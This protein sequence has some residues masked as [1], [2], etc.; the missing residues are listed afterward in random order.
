LRA[1]SPSD[2]LAGATPYL[3]MMGTL[4]GAHL[5]AKGALAARARLKNSAAD[6]AFLETRIAVAEFFA[7]QLL[8]PTTALLAPIMRGASGAF[9]LEADALAQ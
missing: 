1:G 9:A 5:L 2:A 3:K 4:T 7:T 8:P 6:K